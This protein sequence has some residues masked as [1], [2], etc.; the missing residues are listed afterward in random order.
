MKYRLWS[1]PRSFREL[2]SQLLT[3]G[4]LRRIGWSRSVR[5]NRPQ[6]AVGEPMPWLT[7]P[8]VYWLDGVLRSDDHLL[9]LGAGQSTRWFAARVGSVVSVE[10]DPRWAA[11]VSRGAPPNIEVIAARCQGDELEADPTDPYISAIDALGA[12]SFDLILVDGMA[13][14]AATRA[15]VRLLKPDGAV[16]IDNSDRPVLTPAVEHLAEEGFGRIDFV[17]FTPGGSNF[18]CTSVF[19]QDFSRW[20]A[21][22]EPPKWWGA[23]IAD[24]VGP[25]TA[26]PAYRGRGA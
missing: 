21:R 2:D 23:D 1:F 4:T 5:E 6:T 3:L 17:G 20:V 13:R 11:R 18:S 24:F 25:D 10:H 8:V 14:I 26:A 22:D 16:V 15:S 7:Y 12:G 19:A 9:E